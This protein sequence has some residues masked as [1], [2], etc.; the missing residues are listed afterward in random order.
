MNSNSQNITQ[1]KINTMLI[2]I[3]TIQV[4]LSGMSGK[5]FLLT[6]GGVVPTFPQTY[7]RS[8]QMKV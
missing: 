8:H 3:Q 5:C 4:A 2:S 6:S 1:A 7:W